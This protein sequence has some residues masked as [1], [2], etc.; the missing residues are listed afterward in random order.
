MPLSPV[1]LR[2]VATLLCQ[3]KTIRGIRCS[4]ALCPRPRV[5]AAPQ[6]GIVPFPD[7]SVSSLA[8]IGGAPHP[9]R[10]PRRLRVQVRIGAL[11]VSFISV[12]AH[13]IPDL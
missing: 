11:E 9:F 10:R 3:A 7:V 2:A 12:R 13:D 8:R 4:T 1:P 5:R 6:G